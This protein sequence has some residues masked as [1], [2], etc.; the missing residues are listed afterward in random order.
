MSGSPEIGSSASGGCGD[1][2]RSWQDPGGRT[3]PGPYLRLDLRFRLLPA[4]VARRRR[5]LFAFA[6]P[7]GAAGSGSL[8]RMASN[9]SSTSAA[10][11]APSACGSLASRLAAVSSIRLRSPSSFSHA[12]A[13]CCQPLASSRRFV[14]LRC[15]S[16]RSNP[17]AAADAR[18]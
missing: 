1:I 14:R 6:R 2:V 3:P 15:A 16:A 5:G 12:R 8:S 18:A 10:S 4:E 13:A 7:A 17:P 11:E 9:I